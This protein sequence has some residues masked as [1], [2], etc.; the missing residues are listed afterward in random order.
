MNQ[1]V[2]TALLIAAC[3]LFTIILT[4]VIPIIF[5]IRT[6][7]TQYYTVLASGAE[8]SGPEDIWGTKPPDAVSEENTSTDI[9]MSPNPDDETSDT[10]VAHARII[11]ADVGQ[12]SCAIIQSGGETAVFD[13]G[14]TD[15]AQVPV[16][17]LKDL[18]VTDISLCCVTHW[19][20]DHAGAAIGILKNF[21]VKQFLY[22]D[23]EADTR[24][25]Q[26]I[27]NYISEHNTPSSVPKVGDQ[28]RIGELVMTITGPLRYDYEEENSNS[29]SAVFSYNGIPYVFIGG[30]TTEE[31]ERDIVNA[32]ISVDSMCM[33][34]NHHGSTTSSCRE[35]ITAVSP[36]YTIISC[37]KDND[38]GHPAPSVLKRIR[39]SGSLLYRTD[40]Q[41]DIIFEVTDDGLEFEKSPTEDWTPGT[42]KIK[43]D[44]EN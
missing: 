13:T 23:Y 22:A 26:S 3:V 39:E 12:G 28:Y 40:L 38:Y 24:T 35:F 7:D 19:D 4:I 2:R 20:N 29:I 32:G 34:C 33:V 6:N 9:S 21:D 43:E 14:S 1:R 11:I 27:K 30:D 15:T 44:P 16:R 5:T 37:G 10:A 25:Y 31:S 41:G 8:T 17:I 36:K 42:V 18:G